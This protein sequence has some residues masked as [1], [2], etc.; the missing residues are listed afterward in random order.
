MLVIFG[1]S[2]CLFIL[3]RFV[4]LFIGDVSEQGSAEEGQERR[5][6]IMYM[7]MYG[8]D[9]L[10]TMITMI[11]IIQMIIVVIMIIIIF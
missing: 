2:L 5:I 3:V 10:Y 8:M 7:N 1:Y 4:C 9:V 6:Y 11:I